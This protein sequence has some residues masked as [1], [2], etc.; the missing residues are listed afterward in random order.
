MGWASYY[1]DN[2]DARGESKSSKSR[3]PKVP[4]RREPPK[5]Q[6]VPEDDICFETLLNNLPIPKPSRPT[7]KD[8][9]DA[10]G[11]S[12]QPKP[13]RPKPSLKR[14]ESKQPK[15]SLKARQRSR[16]REPRRK[17]Y[18]PVA[19]T[20]YVS[21]DEIQRRIQREI[22]RQEKETGVYVLN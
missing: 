4:N 2:I 11:E 9:I 6:Y 17:H 8:D 12:K 21:P 7:P 18:V 1:E 22:I 3:K 5:K 20:R 10:R 16:Q 15:P 19:K 14:G 13:L